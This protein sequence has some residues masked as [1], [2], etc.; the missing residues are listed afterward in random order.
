MRIV[1][2]RMHSQFFSSICKL[3]LDAFKTFIY[4][5]LEVNTAMQ[6]STKI[7]CLGSYRTILQFK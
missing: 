3:N 7:S 2:L 6:K 1:D 4:Q 5:L